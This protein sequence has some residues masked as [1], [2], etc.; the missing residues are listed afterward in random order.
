[1]AEALG[2]G[3]TDKW[4]QTYEGAENFNFHIQNYFQYHNEAFAY[5]FAIVMLIYLFFDKRKA[6]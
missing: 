6:V 1:M 5:S 3:L 2:E 4:V